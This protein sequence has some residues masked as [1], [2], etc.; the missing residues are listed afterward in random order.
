MPYIFCPY[1]DKKVFI[2]ADRYVEHGR[3]KSSYNKNDKAVSNNGRKETYNQKGK[4]Q[5]MQR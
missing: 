1:C 5:N 2:R 4:V 3:P